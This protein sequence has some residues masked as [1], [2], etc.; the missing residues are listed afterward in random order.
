MLGVGAMMTAIS[1][2][3]TATAAYTGWCG[4]WGLVAPLFAFASTTGFVVANSITGALADF[5]KYAGTVSALT[6]AI[7]YGSGIVGSGLVGLFADGTPW[8]M[9]WVIGVSGTGCLL[10]IGLIA[11]E[12]SCRSI[13]IC[14]ENAADPL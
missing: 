1:A 2:I 14:Y 12:R 11:R 10:S 4:L 13:G 5:P 7:Q 3:A 6:G 9:G 8:P